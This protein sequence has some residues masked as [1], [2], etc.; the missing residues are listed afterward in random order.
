MGGK[1][2]EI[3]TFYQ[4]SG[5]NYTSDRHSQLKDNLS[6]LLALPEVFKG[7]LRLRERENSIDNVEKAHLHSRNSGDEVLKVLYRASVDAP[8]HRHN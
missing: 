6:H 2:G 8:T 5:R 3:N 4:L 7:L 1:L